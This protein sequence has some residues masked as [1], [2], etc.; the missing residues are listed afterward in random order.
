MDEVREFNARRW[1][2]LARA[3][4][5]YT[6]PALDLTESSARDLIDPFRLLPDLRGEPVLCLAAGGGRQSAAFG[7]LGASVTVVDICEAQLERDLIASRHYGYSVSTVLADMRDLSALGSQAFAVV[8]Q[9]YSIN[10]SPEVDSVLGEVSRVIRPCG[11]YSLMFAN[12]TALGVSPGDWNGTAYPLRERYADHGP[13][14]CVDESWVYRTSPAGFQRAQPPREYRHTWSQVLN[15]LCRA[16]FVVV[17]LQEHHAESA[18][19]GP[20]T[21]AHFTSYL[22]P[23]FT[24][25]ARR[26]E[27]AA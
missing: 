26:G 2:A 6:Q 21:W 19:Q 22:P 27:H 3:G 14:Q 20:G 10:F 15:G 5:L 17:R 25:W 18:D 1:A 16:G 24:L 11:S 8:S 7:I 13:V 4:A 23:W 12:P 9:P